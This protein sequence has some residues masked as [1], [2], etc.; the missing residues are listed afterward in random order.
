METKREF[1]LCAAIK[2]NSTR[3]CHKM[4]HNNDIYD[5]ELGYRHADIFHRFGKDISR[6]PYDQGFYTSK[7][8]FVNR[9]E[10]AKIAFEA[11]QIDEQK[12]TLFSEDL[13]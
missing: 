3:E 5:I 1:I 8:R 2:R 7:G 4:Y 6:D 10:A 9:E 12:K 13:Y 11:G